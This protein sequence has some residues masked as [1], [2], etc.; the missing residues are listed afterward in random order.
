MVNWQ[1]LIDNFKFKIDLCVFAPL[2]QLHYLEL[3][4]IQ[5]W[6]KMRKYLWRDIQV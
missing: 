1:L 4:G 2:W 3:K 6:K 5:L